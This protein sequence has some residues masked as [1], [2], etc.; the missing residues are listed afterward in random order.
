MKNLILESNKTLIHHI[1]SVSEEFNSI[2]KPLFQ[3]LPFSY[4]GYHKFYK[5]GYY[6]VLSSN[7]EFTQLWLDYNMNNDF[8][9][10]S[11]K[12]F[13]ISNDKKNFL[14]KIKTTPRNS[15]YKYL[16]PIHDKEQMPGLSLCN[17]FNMHYGIHLFYDTVEYLESFV[18]GSPIQGEAVDLY[19]NHFYIIERFMTYFKN[20]AHYLIN[21]VD[22]KKM[23]FSPFY[24]KEVH[25]AMDNLDTNRNFI[26]NKKQ[27]YASTQLSK[28]S[29]DSNPDICL[30]KKEF[31]CLY[32]LSLGKSA[33]EIAA[34][35][36]I[37][38]RTIEKHLE[39]IRAKYN[40]QYDLIDLC[41]ANNIH[42]F[43]L[44]KI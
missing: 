22:R 18:F 27:F 35:L 34:I 13:F 9:N 2:I 3:D 6:M 7:L 44:D 24:R 37:S 17:E 29:L 19:L 1:N 21:P 5:D 12:K 28:I 8:S 31:E 43:H 16:W 36:S 38:W 30:T 23:A 32:Y 26:V 15:I 42:K 39:N 25:K 14:E 11:D 40:F 33:K 20:K 4:F 41:N 10:D